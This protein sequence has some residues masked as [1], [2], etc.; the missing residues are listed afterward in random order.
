MD[1]KFSNFNSIYELFAGISS[2]LVGLEI[3]RKY[4]IKYIEPFISNQSERIQDRIKNLEIKVQ[5]TTDMHT[6]NDNQKKRLNEIKDEYLILKTRVSEKHELNVANTKFETLLWLNFLYCCFVLIIG[7]FEDS[8]FFDNNN[9]PFILVSNTSAFIILAII[10]NLSTQKIW[11]PS[12]WYSGILM[13]NASILLAYTDHYCTHTGFPWLPWVS[14]FSFFP[15]W[16]AW[17][18]PAVTIFITLLVI[19]MPFIVIACR[20]PLFI[21]KLC[22]SVEDAA[23]LLDQE[24]DN[25]LKD[26]QRQ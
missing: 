17:G 19:L 8:N 18:T 4:I 26:I 6:A 24:S 5:V 15:S 21:Y 23:T 12:N 3:I 22:P 10:L 13:A 1:I 20:I 14:C 11:E 2:A 16:L 9:S 7:G 25:I